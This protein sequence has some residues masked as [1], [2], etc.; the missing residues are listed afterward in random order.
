MR[1]ITANK[2]IADI[3]SITCTANADVGVFFHV[4]RAMGGRLY[5]IHPTAHSWEQSPPL[6]QVHALR[7]RNTAYLCSPPFG[8]LGDSVWT[9]V[10]LTVHHRTSLEFIVLQRRWLRR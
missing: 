6:T 5:H 2:L 9:N 8:T 10:Y 7:I 1:P 4:L 3:S